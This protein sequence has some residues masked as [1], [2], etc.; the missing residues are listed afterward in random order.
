MSRA[1]LLLLWLTIV[2]SAAPP[3][4]TAVAAPL[5]TPSTDTVA[6]RMQKGL[7]KQLASIRKQAS[8]Y[9][10]IGEA[11]PPDSFLL[12]WPKRTSA[13]SAVAFTEPCDPMP[14]AE[15]D[16][17]VGGAATR[18]NV[19]PQLIRAMITQESGGRPCAVSVAGAQGLMQ[20]MPEVQRELAV[21]DPFDA[22]QSIE[23]GAKLLRNLMDRYAGDVPKALAAYN[24]GPG[25]VDRASG[26]PPIPETIN[27][28]AKI[29]KRVE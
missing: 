2:V 1:V 15:L 20:L 24:A 26:I 9:L 19:S 12:P 22:R 17:L 4:E 8:G 29:I 11:Q 28:V 10:T 13:A 3:Q 23:A 18:Q 6:S 25:A 21:D 27:Y 7:E 16:R 14:E 5:S